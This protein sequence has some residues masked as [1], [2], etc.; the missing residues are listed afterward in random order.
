MPPLPNPK[1]KRRNK[2][3]IPTTVLLAS[4]PDVEAPDVPDNVE[5][6][7]VGLDWWAWAWSQ[8]QACAWDDG[9][10]SFIAR[11]AQLEEALTILRSFEVGPIPT[12][13]AG[14]DDYLRTLKIVCGHLKALAG[15]EIAVMR[16]MRELDNRL[17][18]NPKALAELRWTIVAPVEDE[19][20]GTADRVGQQRED[21]RTRLEAV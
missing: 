10:V 3:T 1:R 7:Q 19:E 17:G 6:G 14:L 20:T 2:P 21:R 15:G 16:E 4:G 18:L 13:T 11:R 12:D 8:P 5:L 9:S